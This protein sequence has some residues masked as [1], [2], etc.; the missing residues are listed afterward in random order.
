MQIKRHKKFTIL[1]FC[2]VL[3]LSCETSTT[4]VTTSSVAQLSAFYFAKNDSFPGLGNAVFTIEERLDTGLVWNKDSMLFGT[5]LDTVIPKFTFAATPSAA[6]LTMPDTTVV[7]TGYDTLDFSKTPIY[8]T[9]RSSDKTTT[10]VYEIQPRVHQVNPDLYT[11]QQL[12]AQIYPSDDSEQ[13]V[14]LLGNKFVMLSSNGFAFGLIVRRTA[15][16]GQ[17]SEH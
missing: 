10:K 13:R 6:Y 12:T 14:V 3:L 7:L 1:L 8:L 9:I 4:T 15:R 5:R 17:T 2:L 16:H 11:W